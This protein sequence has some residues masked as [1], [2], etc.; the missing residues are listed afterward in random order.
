M[1]GKGLLLKYNFSLPQLLANVF[2]EYNL[3]IPTKSVKKSQYFLK[4]CLKTLF[5]KE[6][7]KIR[8][9]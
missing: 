1:G 9:I 3:N 6:G 7:K 5:P 8:N 2:P 4:S